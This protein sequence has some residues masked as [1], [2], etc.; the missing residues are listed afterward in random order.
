MFY[1]YRQAEM[2]I[3]TYGRNRFV[4]EIWQHCIWQLRGSTANRIKHS[5]SPQTRMRSL[6]LMFW[7]CGVHCGRHVT[8]GRMAHNAEYSFDELTDVIL[9]NGEAERTVQP[10]HVCT[11]KGIRND[12]IQIAGHSF[13]RNVVCEKQVLCD[14]L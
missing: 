14:P 13:L 7:C 11:P 10:L 8:Y 2:F 1:T 4:C 3:Q 9:L 12:G 6:L 5:F